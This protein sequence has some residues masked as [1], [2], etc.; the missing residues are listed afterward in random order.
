MAALPKSIIGKLDS[1]N[2][3]VKIGVDYHFNED[4]MAFATF[5]QGFKAGEFGARA[6]SVLTVGPTDDEESDSFE[7][8]IKS[9]L[10]EGRLRVNATLFQTKFENLQFGVFIPSPTNP[11]GQE[12]VNQNIGEATNR[13][14]E[15]EITSI[16]IDGLTLQASFGLLDAE[17]DKFCADLD[18]PS[19]VSSTSNCGGNVV[20]LPG[21]TFLVDEDHT[22][23]ELS[24][25][26]DRQIYLSSEYEWNTDIGGLFVRAA[27]SYE[28]DYFSDGVLNHPKAK[29]GDFWLWDASFG[30]T[31][32]DQKWR[33]QAWCK[34]CGDKEYTSGLTPTAQFFNQHFWGLPRMYGLTFDYSR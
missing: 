9:D 16:P 22:S 8:G 14:L 4:L 12:T 34:N 28:S 29:T 20:A 21:G 6:D 30:W 27:G 7:I 3:S 23:L 5:S 10:L 31:S 25:A 1:N 19:A 32:L 15:V 33:I 24:R 13:G 17:Y 26:P 18:G 2:T 11:T